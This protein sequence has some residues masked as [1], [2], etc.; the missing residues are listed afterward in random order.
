MLF[1]TLVLNLIALNCLVLKTSVVNNLAKNTKDSK[2]SCL[3]NDDI[4]SLKNMIYKGHN[5]H[6][7]HTVFPLPSLKLPSI[8]T[9]EEVDVHKNIKSSKLRIPAKLS[10]SA[11]SDLKCCGIDVKEIKPKPKGHYE[12]IERKVANYF[13]VSGDRPSGMPG[14]F[15]VSKNEAKMHLG[16]ERR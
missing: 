2:Q 10:S 12:R 16:L 3:T 1:L 9:K 15:V 13:W 6:H 14:S 7:H 11:K 4:L 5:H 8:F